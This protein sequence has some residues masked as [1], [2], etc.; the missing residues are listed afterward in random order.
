MMDR[1]RE[2]TNGLAVKIILSLIIFSFVFAGVGSYLVGGTQSIAAKVGDREISRNEFE[3]VYQNER[4]RMQSQL[5]EYFST[6]LGDPQYVQQLRQNILDRMVNDVLLEQRASTL[7]LRISDEQIRQTIVTMPSFQNN[8]A[9]DKDVYA[10]ALRRAGY[11]PDSFAEYLRQDMTRTQLIS[12]LQSSDFALPS[13][14]ALQGELETQQREIRTIT[15]DVAK[16]AENADISE[17]DIQA[18]YDENQEQF[19]RP[20]QVKVAYIELS[21]NTLKSQVKVTD[22]EA[23]DY[24]LESLDKY[25]TAE[26]RKVSH[27]MVEGDDEARAQS[28][29][30][31]VNAGEDFAAVAKDSSDDTFSAQDGGALD[32]FERGVMDPAFEDAAYD[33][34]A[35]G[36]VSGLVKSEFGYHIIKLDDIE[37]PTTKPFSEVKAEIIA[38]LQDEKAVDRFYELQTTLAEVAFEMPD[39]LD[40]AALAID[41]TVSKTEFFARGGAPEVLSAPAVQQ[42]IFSPEVREDGLNSEVIEI[43]PEHVIVVRVEEFRD[44]TILPLEEVNGD[45]QARLAQSKGEQAALTLSQAALSALNS[46]SGEAFLKDNELAFGESEVINRRAPLAN[47]VFRFVKPEQGQPVYGQ[48]KDYAGN[49]VLV[50]LDKVITEADEA[51]QEQVAASLVRTQTQ[52]ELSATLEVLRSDET[53]SFPLLEEAVN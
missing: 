48:A 5:G 40:D 17:Q 15:L 44:E 2:G 31:R 39:S 35:A 12:A 46:G 50:S 7:G 29:L 36:D 24:Y 23:D 21:G 4:N 9:F 53:I 45:V 34:A 27:I 25:S 37:K 1:I 11:T 38:Q 20:E 19:M 51:A 47:D 41:A 28:L 14:I 3:Q 16:F 26:K 49:I 30:D 8:G 32:W 43:A 33:L 10:A 42:A 18:Y 13:E 6:L 22:A 52:L